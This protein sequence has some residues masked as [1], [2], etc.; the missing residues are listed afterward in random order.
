MEKVDRSKSGLKSGTLIRIRDDT[1]EP[2]LSAG[3]PSPVLV[4]EKGKRYRSFLS[5]MDKEI[6]CQ[7][8]AQGASFIAVKVNTIRKTLSASIQG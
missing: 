1:F 6:T 2:G 5:K 4:L 8:A 3:G 7:P